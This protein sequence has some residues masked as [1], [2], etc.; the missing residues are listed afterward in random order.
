MR[1]CLLALLAIIAPVFLTGCIISQKEEAWKESSPLKKDGTLADDFWE[2]ATPGKDEQLKLG[3]WPLPFQFYLKSVG[4]EQNGDA[5][6]RKASWNDLG[7]PFLLMLP[8]RFSYQD[9]IYRKGETTPYAT[10]DIHANPF[11]TRTTFTD[12]PDSHTITI[13]GTPILYTKVDT[14]IALPGQQ[15][16]LRTRIRNYFWTLGPMYIDAGEEHPPQPPND[17]AKGYVFFPLLLGGITGPTLWTSSELIAHEPDGR[18][19]SAE[20]SHGPLFGAL[21]YRHRRTKLGEIS[22]NHYDTSHSLLAGILWL[23][24]ATNTEQHKTINAKNGPLW[25]MFGWGKKDG[26]PA[27]RILW[28]PIGL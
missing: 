28:V 8:L 21:G 10:Y 13:Q 5:A 1:H 9:A 17:D 15:E 16:R 6:M 23:D 22:E 7:F 11:W 27:V 25:A 24:R 14:M 18:V 12:R 4:V 19:I 26:R 20:G 3:F 2:K